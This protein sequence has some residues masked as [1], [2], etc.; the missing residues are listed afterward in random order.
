[1]H[2]PPPHDDPPPPLPPPPT[3]QQE[4]LNALAADKANIQV[5]LAKLEEKLQDGYQVQGQRPR[6]TEADLEKQMKDLEYKRTTQSMSLADEKKIL[7]Q[8]GLFKKEKLR[9][10]GYA[11]TEGGLKD[12]K[13]RKTQ[14]FDERKGKEAAMAELSQGI[15]KLQLAQR[16]GV[17]ADQLVMVPFQVPEACMARLV[18]KGGTNIR[19]I[20]EIYSVSID[21]DHG[22]GGAGKVSGSAAACALAQQEIDDVAN[23]VNEDMRV[24]EALTLTLLSGRAALAQ[25]LMAEHRVRIEVD[26]E[27]KVVKAQGLP[28]Q[29]AALKAALAALEGQCVSHKVVIDRKL[30]GPVVGKGGANLRQLEQE[31]PGVSIDLNRDEGHF[32]VAGL[33]EKVEGVVSALEHL[34]TTLEDK[35]E[36]VPIDKFL[37][38][39]LM[40]DA[41]RALKELRKATGCNLFVDMK[42]DDELGG[43]SVKGPAG[44]LEAAV[45]EVLRVLASL[46]AQTLNMTVDPEMVRYIIG[47]KGAV[48]NALREK[49]HTLIEAE[50][51]S[52][53]LRIFH[54]EE[55]ARLAAK[56]EILKVVEK[57]QLVEVAVPKQVAIALKGPKGVDLRAQCAGPELEVQLD[58]DPSKGVVRVRGAPE[59]AA[60]VRGLLLAFVEENFSA[61]MD[62][63]PEDFQTLVSGGDNALKKQVQDATGVQLFTVKEENL[64]RIQGPRA[65]VAE[66]EAMLRQALEGG[67]AEGTTVHVPVHPDAYPGLMGKAGAGIN[68]FRD[69]HGVALI[70]LR[71]TNR[72]RIRGDEPAKVAKAAAALRK[73]LAG[74]RTFAFVPAE[75]GAKQGLEARQELAAFKRQYE[76]QVEET[77]DGY[78]LRGL[79]AEIAAA[80]DRLKELVSQRARLVIGLTPAQLATLAAT[81]DANWRKIREDF[82]VSTDLDTEKACV[83][84]QGATPA[85]G[86]AQGFLFQMLEILLGGQFGHVAVAA[87]DLPALALPASI[88][89]LKAQTGVEEV[90]LDRQEG[91]V[92]V[93][94]P[95]EAMARVPVAVRSIVAT[96]SQSHAR[97]P[98]EPWMLPYILGK[99]GSKVKELEKSMGVA[100]EIDRDASVVSL[101]PGVPPAA[102][103]KASAKKGGKNGGGVKKAA[104]AAAT[105]EEEGE[106]AEKVEEEVEA[107]EEGAYEKEEEEEEEEEDAVVAEEEAPAV[108]EEARGIAAVQQAKEW[109]LQ[110]MSTLKKELVELRLPQEVIPALIGKKGAN[111]SRIREESKALI[112]VMNNEGGYGR[113]TSG[114]ASSA[115]PPGGLITVRLKGEEAALAKAQELIEAFVS[116]WQAQNVVQEIKVHADQIRLVVGNK[117]SVVKGI[118]EQSGGAK[119][120]M[121]RD[122]ALIVVKGSA[123]SVAKAVELIQAIVDE[124]NAANASKR[125][126]RVTAMALEKES[127]NGSAST[128]ATT[129][130]SPASSSPHEANPAPP[131]A[132]AATHHN[133]SEWNFPT[134]PPGAD[135]SLAKQL[136]EKQAEAAAAKANKNKKKKTRSKAAAAAAKAAESSSSPPASVPAV[137]GHGGCGLEE[138]KEGGDKGVKPSQ[139]D[140]AEGKVVVA[141]SDGPSMAKAAQA[142]VPAKAHKVVAEVVKTEK[143]GELLDLI[144]GGWVVDKETTA[145]VAAPPAKVEAAPAV[146]AGPSGF[147]KATSLL[148][149]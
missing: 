134:V 80:R 69:D 50:A 126:E 139:Q 62:L 59:A 135:A 8:I 100:V 114:P 49:T 21:F 138:T 116:E 149:L 95:A 104:P 87:T 67:E 81:G 88:E 20:E 101:A 25:A 131:P 3:K 77:P 58:I 61:E 130:A 79:V 11:Q 40:D 22:R 48:I 7:R 56:E 108:D 27:R 42:K 47:K 12:L 64:L 32:L 84:L 91:L 148:R 78:K 118:A 17:S 19:R 14:L 136:M 105:T 107:Q 111:L 96:W 28:T 97:V 125:A 29:L 23:A 33:A 120:D 141:K 99:A 63:P 39:L 24:S 132:T 92:R 46:Q 119:I 109:L 13:A 74:M 117:G 143:A 5:E 82:A 75:K 44:T 98:F 86:R 145:T 37:A 129:N 127:L 54:P 15:R 113:S 1:M 52:G 38:H 31:Y 83:V 18:G 123:A 106:E 26:R 102:G 146:E 73:L 43:L 147:F 90:W 110:E 121:D 10:K 2:H 35:E 65:A 142:P 71:T 30:F 103:K 34:S 94:G 41:G 128:A 137:N 70:V 72:V 115:A 45:A 51:R 144:M 93:R 60:T 68:K 36:R 133:A 112:D 122:R 57:N 66:A 89:A 6:E 16:V 140:G 9:I 4:R 124:D 55:A 53:L 85:V 76:V